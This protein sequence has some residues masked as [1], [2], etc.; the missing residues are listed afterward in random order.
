M[1]VTSGQANRTIRIQAR[2]AAD[3]L[4]ASHQSTINIPALATWH[5]FPITLTHEPT[6]VALAASDVVTFSVENQSAAGDDLLLNQSG[7]TDSTVFYFPSSTVINVDEVDIYSN[8]YPDITL[9]A[10]AHAGTTIF[11]SSVG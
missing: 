11:C 8:P 3:E 6:P 1:R 10:A 2:N 5:Q 7:L 9:A 4:L